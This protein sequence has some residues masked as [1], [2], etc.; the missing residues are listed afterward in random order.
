MFMMREILPANNLARD[1]VDVDGDILLVTRHTGKGNKH[2]CSR[3]R[4]ENRNGEQ[5]QREKIVE[6]LALV[7]HGKIAT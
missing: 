1:W 4:G 3:R 2:S 5:Q 6:F 7:L